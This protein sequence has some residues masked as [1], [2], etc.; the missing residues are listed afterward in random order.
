M[1]ALIP[2]LNSAALGRPAA[3]VGNRCHVANRRHLEA[4]SLQRPQ[5]RFPTGAGAADLDFDHFMPCSIAARP[6]WSAATCAA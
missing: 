3:I 4:A 6:A 5:S 1:G 2:E